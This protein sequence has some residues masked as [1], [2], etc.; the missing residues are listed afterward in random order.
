MSIIAAALWYLVVFD[1]DGGLVTTPMPFENDEQCQM[2]KTEF[3]EKY[4]TATWDTEC[5]TSDQ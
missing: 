4:P 5:I 3:Q 1:T 2:A